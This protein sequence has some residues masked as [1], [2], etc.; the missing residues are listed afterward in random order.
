[1]SEDYNDNR[2]IQAQSSETISG[3]GGGGS[4]ITPDMD[5]VCLLYTS[6]AADE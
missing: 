1:M 4:G 2:T 3:D 5:Y 6:D